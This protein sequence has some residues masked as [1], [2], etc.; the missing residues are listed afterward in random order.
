M[1]KE[2]RVLADHAGLLGQQVER[3]GGRLLSENDLAA[4]RFQDQPVA[5]V[6]A[7]IPL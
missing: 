6:A 7:E 1:S 5:A 4:T 3:L 2:A